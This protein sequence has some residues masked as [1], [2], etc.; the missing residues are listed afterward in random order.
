MLEAIAAKHPR[1]NGE[2]VLAE[3]V[4]MVAGTVYQPIDFVIGKSLLQ[5]DDLYLQLRGTGDFIGAKDAVK[6]RMGIVNLL[7]RERKKKGSED[8][9]LKK[10]V[11]LDP[12]EL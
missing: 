11:E 5:L 4:E 6:A 3:A 8:R 2:Q 1:L 12:T 9:G 10:V 7:L